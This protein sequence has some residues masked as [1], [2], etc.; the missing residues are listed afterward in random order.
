MKEGN[1]G[2]KGGYGE[3][4]LRKKIEKKEGRELEEW[5][6]GFMGGKMQEFSNCSYYHVPDVFQSFTNLSPILPNLPIFSN[7]RFE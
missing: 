2:K 3:K 5:K 1:Q 7:T 4:E 6:S